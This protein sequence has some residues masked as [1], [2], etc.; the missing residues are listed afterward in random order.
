MLSDFLN[1]ASDLHLTFLLDL[2][3]L[4]RAFCSH[5]RIVKS[6]DFWKHLVEQSDMMSIEVSI[7]DS[8]QFWNVILSCAS[9]LNL[10]NKSL[11]VRARG[12]FLWMWCL[13]DVESE[14]DSDLKRASKIVKKIQASLINISVIRSLRL[15][16]AH[17][18]FSFIH[19]WRCHHLDGYGLV[20]YLQ[21]QQQPAH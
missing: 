13:L 20:A 18:L 6:N 3:V 4:I 19:D 5:G 16:S 12:M 8:K 9:S 2:D 1:F 17:F 14:L 7:T 21:N 15:A 10:R 11:N